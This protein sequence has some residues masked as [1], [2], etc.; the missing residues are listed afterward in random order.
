MLACM[1][2]SML[3]GADIKTI[4]SLK[5]AESILEQLDSNALVVF[6]VD[7]TLIVAIDKIR[8]KH[9]Q[10]IIDQFKQIHF[11]DQVKDVVHREY[12]D[13]IK[14][15]MTEQILVESESSYLIAAL[16][17]K[18]I[19]VIALTHMHAGT[20][21]AIESMEKW[22]SEQLCH[23]AID[24]SVHNPDRIVL[25]NLPM[26]RSSY[27]V[28]HKGILATSRSCSKGQALAEL[29]EQLNW[30][31]S[32]VV[33]FD[34]WQEHLISVSSEMEKLGIVCTAFH[35]KAT[36]IVDSAVDIELAKFQYKHL[37][38]HETWLSDMQA[39]A[40]MKREL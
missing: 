34:D 26:G 15:K 33:F 12:L 14:L 18:S 3:C 9:P 30:K 37:I 20:Y 7:E 25:Q 40:L 16:Q 5:E 36:E 35:Y 23:L 2:S 17:A 1:F 10:D 31:P 27:P 24:M 21:Y 39:M 22:R 29:L 38:E 6:D 13:S 32:S 11:D 4:F 19:R 8:R 28:F